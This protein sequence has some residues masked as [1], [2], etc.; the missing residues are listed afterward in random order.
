MQTASFTIPSPNNI[1]NNFGLSSSLINVNA[2]TVSEALMTEANNNISFREKSR[3][4][5]L[6]KWKNF[7]PFA[8]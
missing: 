8:K 3:A 7:K 4:I 1:A 6:D 2:A 5:S